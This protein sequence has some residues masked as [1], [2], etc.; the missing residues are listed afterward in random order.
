MTILHDV[1]A[2][3]VTCDIKFV[4]PNGLIVGAKVLKILRFDSQLEVFIDQSPGSKRFDTRYAYLIQNEACLCSVAA[5]L[6][7]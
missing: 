2:Y 4:G 5:T 3:N 1:F 6:P 7:I